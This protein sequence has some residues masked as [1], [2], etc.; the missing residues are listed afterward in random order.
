[1]NLSLCVL[2]VPSREEQARRLAEELGAS[3]HIDHYGSPTKAHANA[4]Y[5]ALADARCKSAHYTEDW[6]G[7]I[8]DDAI[9]ADGATRDDLMH[10][11]RKAPAD[12]VSGYLGR[13]KPADTQPHIEQALKHDPHYVITYRL[14]HHVAVFMRAKHVAKAAAYLREHPKFPC[15][16]A[17][18][19]WAQ[20]AGEPVAYSVPS[21]FDHMDSEP[22]I[23]GRP[24]TT[25]DPAEPRIAWVLGDR[26]DWDGKR[27]QLLD[28]PTRNRYG[29]RYGQRPAQPA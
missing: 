3:L 22:V 5:E 25:G 12:I 7:V 9:L 8:E 21:Q 26:D 18:G 2:T 1:M 27:I 20:T 14:L 11:L 17:L 13:A 16:E 6:V 28:Q 10:M 24:V 23:L 29:R 19:I 15:D 4:W